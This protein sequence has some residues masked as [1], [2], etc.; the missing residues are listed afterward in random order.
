MTDPLVGHATPRLRFEA[1]IGRGGMGAVYRGVQLG[2]GRP[3][4]IKVI[5]PERL[6]DPRARERFRRE[7]HTLGLLVHPHVVACHAVG[8]EPGPDGRPL[9]VM[10]ME[11]V[12]GA[13]LGARIAAGAAPAE[14]LEWLRQAAL[15]LHAAH[16]L[17]IVHRDVKPDNILVGRDGRAR[18]GDFG[19][20]RSRGGGDIQVTMPGTLVGSPAYLAPEVCRGDEPGPHADC[21]ALGVSLWQAATGELPFH[22]DNA[23]RL[24]HLHTTQPPPR[25]AFRRPA[26]A[27]LE[28]LVQACL[29]KHPAERPDAG[30]IAEALAALIP[31]LDAT[32]P[33]P[34]AAAAPAVATVVDAPAVP[35]SPPD[36]PR[37]TRAVGIVA[38]LASAAVAALAVWAGTGSAGDAAPP[39]S[40]PGQTDAGFADRVADRV[41]AIEAQ[42]AADPER[43]LAR[44]DDL[45]VPPGL[46]ARHRSAETRILAALA[47]DWRRRHAAAE[48]ALEAGDRATA[49]AAL[50]GS[51]PA[52]LAAALARH[53]ALAARLAALR[54]LAPA[55]LLLPPADIVGD[56]C[57]DP[58]AMTPLAGH[59]PVQGPAA[60]PGRIRLRLPPAEEGAQVAALV[61]P[62]PADRSLAIIVP[63]AEGER[64]LAV[65]P[66]PGGRWSRVVAETGAVRD[67]ILDAGDGP[68]LVVAA[69]GIATGRAPA[70]AELAA[71]GALRPIATAGLAWSLRRVRRVDPGFPR[72]DQVR[73]TIPAAF[74]A[75]RASR[76]AAAVA[77]VVGGEPALVRTGEDGPGLPELERL[78]VERPGLVLVWC[79]AG[80]P[81]ALAEGRLAAVGDL[82]V[83]GILVVPVLA[84]PGGDPSWDDL[85]AAADR[86]APGMPWIDLGP[87]R[88]AV[89][90]PDQAEELGLAAAMAELQRRLASR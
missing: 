31:R 35:V 33:A 54:A 2:L 18:L 55:R 40:R 41:R 85:I 82:A 73:L 9:L 29:A 3:V 28:P 37:R 32:A 43:A 19:L 21:Y 57:P 15:G 14:S 25:L 48:R 45:V 74:P 1:L 68:P 16:R 6:A 11:L 13:G 30:A 65:E 47:E 66:M 72:W 34:V 27:V 52:R 36:P 17:G 38:A 84:H 75:L 76:L 60:A 83:R 39:P 67:L 42:A 80:V 44:L 71:P 22:A 50:A 61:H 78:A 62:G 20:A 81:P 53:E 26:L 46:E 51:P 5:A 70:W 4:A 8:E 10:V 23:L 89:P 77:Q 24:V 79:P 86:R 49:A 63:G 7:A 58:P 56:P 69:A 88:Q 59:A 12:E 64:T 87:A 90:D